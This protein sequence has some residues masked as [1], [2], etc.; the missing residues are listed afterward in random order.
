MLFSLSLNTCSAE[1]LS[2]KFERESRH[3]LI[4]CTCTPH[5]QTA[6][7]WKT[8]L[9][10]EIPQVYLFENSTDSSLCSSRGISQ[11]PPINRWQRG[12]KGPVA[13]GV[14]PW[15]VQHGRCRCDRTSPHLKLIFSMLKSSRIMF[16][17]LSPSF[18]FLPHC[19]TVG[20]N[21]GDNSR[22][23]LFPPEQIPIS[24]S[25]WGV[26]I[27]AGKEKRRPCFRNECLPV[28]GHIYLLR[29]KQ[30]SHS[31]VCVC[32]C[33]CVCAC[34]HACV[35]VCQ[36]QSKLMSRELK[37]TIC[38]VSISGLIVLTL[39]YSCLESNSTF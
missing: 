29:T 14:C 25:F 6:N 9:R 35:C 33:V 1:T 18:H 7:C 27:H 16:Y 34:V 2:W 21:V 31:G 36:T 5:L 28:W 17:P 4:S 3:D 15:V 8:L 32:V 10:S 11:R 26:A 39:S 19:L 22:V 12:L 13:A 20:N 23:L 37:D 38:L 24:R 30:N